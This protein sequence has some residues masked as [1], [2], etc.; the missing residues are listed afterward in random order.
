MRYLIIILIFNTVNSLTHDITKL[1]SR[2]ASFISK[3]WLNNFVSDT[4]MNKLDKGKNL[5]KTAIKLFDLNDSYLISSI[6][7]LEEFIQENESD[8]LLYLCWSPKIK[9]SRP[10][11]SLIVVKIEKDILSVK[12]IVQ[13][14]TW[15]PQKIG[16]CKL[17]DAL[18]STTKEY[19]CQDI[20]L[21]SLYENDLRYKLDWS[22]WN[23]EIYN[24]SKDN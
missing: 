14:P 3:R 13:S 24:D 1:T 22:T 2:Q 16:S 6:N 10:I 7:K 18:V 4:L 11:L 20:N 15:D 19:D 23:L 17:R 21:E 5:K 8:K 12:H 9:N